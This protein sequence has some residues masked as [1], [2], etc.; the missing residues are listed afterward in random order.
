[1][2]PLMAPRRD[3]MVMILSSQAPA[4]CDG[5]IAGSRES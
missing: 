2:A 5:R 1:M 3:N 4:A